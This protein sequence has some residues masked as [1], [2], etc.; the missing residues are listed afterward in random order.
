MDI[1]LTLIGI[2]ILWIFSIHGYEQDAD[3]FK[4]KLIA[5]SEE[6]AAVRG[7]LRRCQKLIEDDH[8]EI[9]QLRANRVVPESCGAGGQC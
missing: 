5:M 9:D 2:L 3:R 6:L 4:A 1:V 7:A 8:D